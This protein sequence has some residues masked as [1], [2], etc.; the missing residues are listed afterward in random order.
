MRRRV[1]VNPMLPEPAAK[2]TA[3]EFEKAQLRYMR[4]LSDVTDQGILDSKEL[5]DLE[6]ASREYY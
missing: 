6:Q 1:Q 3:E 2:E 5:L 4:I